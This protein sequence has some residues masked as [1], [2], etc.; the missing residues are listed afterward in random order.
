MAAARREAKLEAAV[1]D[2]WGSLVEVLR[3]P[4]TGMLVCPVC[5]LYWSSN[6]EDMVAHIVSH[7]RGYME[8]LRPAPRE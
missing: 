8:K 6:P 2:V 4:R 3:D 1:I 5:R 7:A